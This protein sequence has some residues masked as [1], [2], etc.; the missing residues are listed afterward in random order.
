MNI[1]VGGSH[2]KAVNRPKAPK[3]LAYGEAYNVRQKS[4][5]AATS[6]FDQSVQAFPS[7]VIGPDR[8]IEPQGTFAEAQAQVSR[9]CFARNASESN[10][11]S[12]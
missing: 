7:I 1:G 10:C 8:S 4:M 12:F 11:V 5:A 6:T 2:V 9:I 3:S